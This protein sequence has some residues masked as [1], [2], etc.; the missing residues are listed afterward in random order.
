[1]NIKYK[2]RE[3]RPF[4]LSIL[5]LFVFCFTA[6]NGLRTG[7]AIFF[8]KT[9]LEYNGHPLYVLVSGGGWLIIGFFLAWSLWRGKTWSRIALII[10]TVGYTV[11]YWFDRLVMQ[12]PHAN[13]PFIL[14]INIVFI[15]LIIFIL[16]SHKTRHYLQK[17][18]YERKPKTSSTS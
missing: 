10:S 5:I 18:A 17:A 7:E 9:F 15:Q 3:G 4:C 14:I 12:E 13:W 2:K 11:W 16:S 6:W 8:W 1:M